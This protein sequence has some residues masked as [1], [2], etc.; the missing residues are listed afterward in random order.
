MPVPLLPSFTN[1]KI[2]D[3]DYSVVKNLL[4]YYESKVIGLRDD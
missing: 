3:Y 1:I 4:K 2:K